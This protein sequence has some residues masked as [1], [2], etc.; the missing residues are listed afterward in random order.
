[1]DAKTELHQV[2]AVSLERGKYTFEC[3]AGH[4]TI[5]RFGDAWVTE[6]AGSKALISLIHE[7]ADALQALADIR[8]ALESAESFG[9]EIDP[10][11]I[12]DIL[13]KFDGR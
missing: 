12:A 2:T 1:M 9:D 13:E 7:C 6:P 3:N 8:G 10:A 5:K 11:D 4:V